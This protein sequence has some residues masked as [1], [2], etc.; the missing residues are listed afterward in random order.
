MHFNL[1]KLFFLIVLLFVS[2]EVVYSQEL[3]ETNPFHDLMVNKSK[4]LSQGKIGFVET[5]TIRGLNESV[6]ISYTLI[7]STNYSEENE[8]I[9][10]N[11]FNELDSI[12]YIVNGTGS[13]IISYKDKQVIID[14]PDKVLSTILPTHAFLSF[15]LGQIEKKLLS[16]NNFTKRQKEFSISIHLTD[17]KLFADYPDVRIIKKNK[18][19]AILCNEEYKFRTKDSLLT[20]H[21]S[22]IAHPNWYAKGSPEQTAIV[23][24]YALI[25]NREDYGQSYF[26]S[27]RNYIEDD[28][29]II[30]KRTGKVSDLIKDSISRADILATIVQLEEKQSTFQLQLEKLESVLI[31]MI[32]QIEEDRDEIERNKLQRK[33]ANGED[34]NMPQLFDEIQTAL[35]NINDSGS[36]RNVDLVKAEREQIINAINQLRIQIDE[37]LEVIKQE[38]ELWNKLLLEEQEISS[39]NN[40]PQLAVVEVNE[41]IE[42]AE[43]IHSV[44]IKEQ[45]ET[46]IVNTL[47]LAVNEVNEVIETTEDIHNVEIKEEEKTTL[48]NTSQLAV[49]EVNEVIETTKDIH[50]AEIKDTIEVKKDELAKTEV[51]QPLSTISNNSTVKKTDQIIQLGYYY[52]VLGCF[53]QSTNATRFLETIKK[54]HANAMD[55]GVSNK[56]GLYMIGIGPYKTRE[57]ANI[58]IKKGVEGWILTK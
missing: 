3:A 2:W 35:I 33:D 48:E 11:L 38:K 23:L 34:N 51:K 32:A 52:I 42:T 54:K 58:V 12:I 17:K 24:H 8:K 15:Y 57:E 53:S 40:T 26:Y 45:E 47:Q 6:I 46:T 31:P 37:Q 27:Y 28:F 56:T 29:R 20:R 19:N 49:V 10:I 7:F 22:K 43:N 36:F 1:K 4:Q 39:V 21:I 41:V 16:S 55:L 14:N 13:Y 9:N 5:K 44:E 18:A 30:D 25:N 50:S